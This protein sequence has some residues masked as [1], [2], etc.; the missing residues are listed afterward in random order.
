MLDSS[1]WLAALRRHKGAYI[2][3]AFRFDHFAVDIH[4]RPARCVDSAVGLLP[5]PGSRLAGD[6]ACR[7]EHRQWGQCPKP[8]VPQE[9][10]DHLA[11]VRTS[12][13]VECLLCIAPLQA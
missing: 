9:I 6:C 13:V 12:R 4:G 5:L 7:H 3:G 1:R 11:G 10:N 8:V 2:M